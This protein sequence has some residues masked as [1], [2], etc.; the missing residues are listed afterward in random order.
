[1]LDRF[2]SPRPASARRGRSVAF[3]LQHEPCGAEFSELAAAVAPT[4]S[5]CLDRSAAYLNWRYREN[6]IERCEIVTH[7]DQLVAYA[8][9]SPEMD[10]AKLLDVFGLADRHLA[11]AML[12]WTLTLLHE[13]GATW[14]STSLFSG[15]P[16]VPFFR[17]V[18]FV[19]RG[20]AP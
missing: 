1:M 7:R 10:G 3:A 13:R 6:P 9:F 15:H 20:S 4:Y 8:V 17:S 5:F 16:W 19:A 12:R 2:L 11:A 14:V 18:G